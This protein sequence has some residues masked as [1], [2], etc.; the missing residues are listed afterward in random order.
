MKN[1]NGKEQ[2]LANH[3]FSAKEFVI[4][5]GFQKE[6]DIVDNRIFEEQDG[7][8]FF[9]EFVYVV[10][11]AGMKNQVAEK[12]FVRYAKNGLGAVKHEGKRRAIG[13]AERYYDT[14]FSIL[15][16]KISVNEKLDY[17]ET[18]PWIGPITKYHL[19]RNLGIDVAKPDRHLVRLAKSYGYKGDSG[20]QQMCEE[21]AKR[22]GDRI[23]VVDVVLWRNANLKVGGFI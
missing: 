2:E 18:L 6:I 10:L 21:I 12:I 11:N 9:T 17:L 16:K 22:T 4:E 5:H 7:I 15:Q 13:K 1:Q 3:Y 20:V 14:W 8:D 23:G 19:A